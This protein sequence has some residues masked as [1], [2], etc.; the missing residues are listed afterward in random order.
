MEEVGTA[1]WSRYF[2]SFLSL[3]FVSLRKN[4]TAG[5]TGGLI[6]DRLTLQF[7]DCAS[8]DY[9]TLFYPPGIAKGASRRPAASR[10]ELIR[11]KAGCRVENFVTMG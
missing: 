2:A 7:Q 5:V 10:L 8:K 11:E 4:D 6:T 3:L 1:R 9:T